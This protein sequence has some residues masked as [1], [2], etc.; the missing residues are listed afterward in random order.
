MA[1]A[2][3]ALAAKVAPIDRQTDVLAD[4]GIQSA[5]KNAGLGYCNVDLSSVKTDG[6]VFS[7]WNKRSL[8]RA[9]VSAMAVGMLK[10]RIC[11]DESGIRIALR[12]AWFTTKLESSLIGKRQADL[13]TLELT[14]AG[15]EALGK[16][17]FRPFGGNH[18]RAAVEQL[19]RDTHLKMKAATEHWT[20]YLKSHEE[21]VQK[22][23][24]K[25]YHDRVAEFERQVGL[26]K[27]DL[28]WVHL[29]HIS[30][31]DLGK[32]IVWDGW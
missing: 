28:E 23:G 8:D 21:D 5:V 9:H 7:T 27:G 32:S 6:W 30:I 22:Q 20:Q 24:Q 26:L 3:D 15:L 4:L 10:K 29:W 12:R 19:V 18:R 14:A 31:W 16:G 1:R 13:P 11:D 17:E 25:E 2:V